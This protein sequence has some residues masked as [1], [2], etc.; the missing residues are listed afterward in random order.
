[1]QIRIDEA[2][3]LRIID[4]EGRTLL[5][6]LDVRLEYPGELHNRL[7]LSAAGT[8]KLSQCGE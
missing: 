8:W 4:A 7:W 2:N 1:M 6:N 3:R 5:D